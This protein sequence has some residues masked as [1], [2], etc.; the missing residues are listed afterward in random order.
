MTSYG[1]LG[2]FSEDI[3]CEPVLVS[4]KHV[5]SMVA[6][7]PLSNLTHPTRVSSLSVAED[8]SMAAVYF[9]GSTEKEDQGIEL[10]NGLVISTPPPSVVQEARQV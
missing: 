8:V 5:Q 1:S 3:D 6:K 9:D 7:A 4:A 2:V 10:V